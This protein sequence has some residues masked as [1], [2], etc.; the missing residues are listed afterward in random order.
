[1][2]YLRCC[3]CLQDK[4]SPLSQDTQPLA[5]LANQNQI[6]QHQQ[7]QLHQPADAMDGHLWPAKPGL[8]QQFEQAYL[9]Q[10]PGLSPM[11]M[12]LTNDTLQQQAAL[13]M[14]PF[15]AN[16]NENDSFPLHPYAAGAGAAGFKDGT[17]NITDNVPGLS[18]LV[19]EDEEEVYNDSSADGSAMELTGNTEVQTQSEWQVQ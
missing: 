9:L 8:E 14:V 1:V 19:E 13:G 6:L 15:G 12:E 3:H 7:L 11:S 16:E 18:T 10:S 4:A 5:E 2:L 17:H